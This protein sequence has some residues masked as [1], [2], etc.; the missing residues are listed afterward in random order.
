MRRPLL[1]TA[2]AATTAL[3]LATGHACAK[4]TPIITVVEDVNACDNYADVPDGKTCAHPFRRGQPVYLL[5]E[6]G[7]LKEKSKDGPHLACISD[8]VRGKCFWVLEDNYL[9]MR[10]RKLGPERRGVY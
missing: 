8:I 5:K 10:Y 9:D 1:Y 7:D 2:L 6:R 4:A 3:T